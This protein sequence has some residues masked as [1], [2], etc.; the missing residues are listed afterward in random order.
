V[1]GWPMRTGLLHGSYPAWRPARW[2]R[3]VGVRQTREL[4]WHVVLRE[5]CSMCPS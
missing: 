4:E 1:A 5:R 3:V 2:F